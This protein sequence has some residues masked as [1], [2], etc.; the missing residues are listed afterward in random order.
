MSV[1]LFG[2][3]E[4]RVGDPDF[5]NHVAVQAEHLHGAVE[6]QASVV[7]GLSEEDVDGVLLCDRVTKSVA[8]H[9]PIPSSNKEIHVFGRIIKEWG[10]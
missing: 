7:P 1:G 4:E 3:A 5:A 6:L 2:V 10:S 9:A 8:L